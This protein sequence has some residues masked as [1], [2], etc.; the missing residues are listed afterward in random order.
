MATNFPGSLDTST[1]QP[2]IASSDEMD[3]SG[4]EHDVVHTNHSGAIIALETKLGSTDSNPSANAVLMGTGSGTSAWDATPTFTGDVTIPDGDLILGSTAVTSTADELNI[5]DGSS[6]AWTT[7]TP[8]WSQGITVGNATQTARYLRLGD[9]LFYELQF[10][11]GST[12]SY[13]TDSFRM[14]LSDSGLPASTS[15]VTYH[16]FG[17]GWVRPTGSGIYSVDVVEVNGVFILY[18]QVASATY[19][20]PSWCKSTVPIT[21]NTSGIIYLC[22]WYRTA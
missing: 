14:N 12:T 18:A 5:L 6:T 11:A 8:S 21:W 1:Q 13:S 10:V 22:G 19:L 9:V 15:S 4:K 3:D 20:Q 17:R 7:F 16:S 2:T